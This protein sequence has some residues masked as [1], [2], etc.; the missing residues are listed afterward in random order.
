MSEYCYYCGDEINMEILIETNGLCI[1]CAD[2]FNAKDY[3]KEMLVYLNDKLCNAFKP[4][5]F[6]I[7]EETEDLLYIGQVT[8]D[9]NGNVELYIE[10]LVLEDLSEQE[11]YEKIKDMILSERFYLLQAWYFE[12]IQGFYNR[13]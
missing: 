3:K 12:E 6:R 2:N 13:I 1:P 8:E 5:C 4:S 7:D 9:N 11:Q 10:E